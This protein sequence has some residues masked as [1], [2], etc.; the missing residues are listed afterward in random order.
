MPRTLFTSEQV[1]SVLTTTPQHLAALTAELTPAQL[2][3]EP[4]PGEWSANDVLTHLRACADMWGGAAA[5]IIAEDHPTI[6]AINPR[7][8][9]KRTDYPRLEFRPSLEAFTAQRAELLAA[10]E[11]LPADGWSRAATVTGAGK[12]LERT[13]L[14]YLTRLAR[15][16]RPHVK[17]IEHIVTALRAS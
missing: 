9:I 2:R 4:S 1:L 3:L 13:V 6:R 5:T 7:T 8:W 12:V 15:H 16:E 10:L 11:S 14:T 17:Q